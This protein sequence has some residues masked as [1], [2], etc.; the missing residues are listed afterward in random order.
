MENPSKRER[1]NNTANSSNFINDT[2]IRLGNKLHLLTVA[3]IG[4]L[5]VGFTI[6]D[7]LEGNDKELCLD[8][9]IFPCLAIIIIPYKLGY[10][11]LSKVITAF[12]MTIIVDLFSL[13]SCNKSSVHFYFIPILINFLIIFQ[14]K[15]KRWSYIFIA[16]GLVDLIFLLSTNYQPWGP[17]I[18]SNLTLQVETIVNTLG[19]TILTLLQVFYLFKINN[20]FQED[21]IEKSNELNRTNHVLRLAIRSREK[22]MSLISHDLRSPIIA[23]QSSIEI[24]SSERES[25]EMKETVLIALKKRIE[26]TLSFIEN[27]LLWASNQN[28]QGKINAEEMQLATFIEYIKNYCTVFCHEKRINFNI[29]GPTEGSIFTDSN[30]LQAIFRNLI[31]N[32]Y[33]FTETGGAISIS[34]TMANDFYKFQIEDNG[35]G[36]N[37]KNL[38]KILSG[39][40]FTTAGTF[41]EKGNGFGIQLVNDFIQSIGS[42]LHIE[43]AESAGSTFYFFMPVYSQ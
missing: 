25:P 24:I 12:I 10:T 13:I 39:E 26:L 6:F 21:L 43:S 38:Q 36:I 37:Q 28:Q 42:K 35:K 4:V 7:Y 9:L 30:M 19:V 8:L 2:F 33:K 32:A 18:V 22:M 34:I 20:S 16:F 40:T 1:E 3:T 23:V 14:G 11:L 29:S 31:S 15:E 17:N 41:N 5:F 27:I